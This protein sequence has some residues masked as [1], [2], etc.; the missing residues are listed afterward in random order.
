MAKTNNYAMSCGCTGTCTCGAQ[1][2][3]IQVRPG[4][5]GARGPQGVQGTQGAQGLTGAGTQG[6]QGPIGPGGG[7]QGTA[8][9]QGAAGTQGV[10]G[11]DGT[12]AQGTQGV[13]GVDGGGVTLQQLSEA[14]QGSAL[15]TTD[16]LS[17]GVTN[18][19]FTTSRVSYIH[20]QGVASAAWTINHNLHFY[21]NVTVQD[22][23]GNIVEG[24]IAYTNS[25]SLIVTFSTAFSGEAYLS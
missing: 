5:G 3:I 11:T 18:L 9:A 7:A 12:G 6:V 8:G 2:I 19:Y 23:A 4:Q 14:I 13:Q 15:S 10:Q 22:S 21:P 24:E 1:G 20:T 25:D 16:D 17:E